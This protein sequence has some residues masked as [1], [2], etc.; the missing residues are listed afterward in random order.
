MLPLRLADRLAGTALF[1]IKVILLLIGGDIDADAFFALPE[2]EK[3]PLWILRNP[4]N[5][6]W[7]AEGSESLDDTSGQVDAKQAF[8][9]GLDLAPDDPRVLA[10]EP[11]RGVNQWPD[12]PGFRETM[13][14]Y[15]DAALDLGPESGRAGAVEHV[16]EVLMI[17]AAHPEAH[18]IVTGEV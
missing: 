9:V 15:Y 11:F 7:A 10:G 14:A 16:E 3:A 18:A 4:H 2:A 17:A 6:G 13:L 1:I 5:R 12:L 8:N